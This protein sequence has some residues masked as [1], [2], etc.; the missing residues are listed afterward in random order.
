MGLLE[1]VIATGVVVSFVILMINFIEKHILPLL[2]SFI[3]K[4]IRTEK[5]KSLS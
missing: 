1:S 3:K 2:L 5:E 4:V